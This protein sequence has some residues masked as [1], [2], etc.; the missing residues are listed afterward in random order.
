MRVGRGAR[1][2]RAASEGVSPNKSPPW[3]QCRS[4]GDSVK[5]AS[6]SPNPEAWGPGL[7]HP[8]LPGT[9]AGL[10]AEAVDFL[11]FQDCHLGSQEQP[12]RQRNAVSG[13]WKPSQRAL[14]GAPGAESAHA[15]VSLSRQRCVTEQGNWAPW[16][17][18]GDPVEGEGSRRR[19]PFLELTSLHADSLLCRPTAWN[20]PVHLLSAFS[21]LVASPLAPVRLTFV[22]LG[23]GLNVGTADI[24]GPPVLCCRGCPE[25]GWVG[26]WVA[27]LPSTRGGPHHATPEW[28]WWKMSPD[29]ECQLS[30]GRHNYP[31]PLKT[32]ALGLSSNPH[33]P[34]LPQTPCWLSL[35]FIKM[36]FL[37]GVGRGTR[38][39]LP[40]PPAAPSPRG[41][42]SL[43]CPVC[44]SICL[45]L[46]SLP[47]P[48]PLPHREHVWF[49]RCHSSFL[50]PSY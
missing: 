28:W 39:Q 21:F 16:R 30:P 14:T 47:L 50:P 33:P 8:G 9:G 4:P 13:S 12:S 6:R 45:S 49:G 10:P 22:P 19:T 44:L 40:L 32:T 1:T 31:P 24:W 2:R 3:A 43:P 29:P 34:P 48:S 46:A 5:P 36:L 25:L 26:C 23:H 42:G 18:V 11:A 35:P 27:S 41:Q 7:I 38:S 37:M 20:S 17:L 15:P